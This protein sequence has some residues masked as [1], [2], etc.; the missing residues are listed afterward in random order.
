MPSSSLTAWTAR[1]AMFNQ[2]NASPEALKAGAAELVQADYLANAIDF[3]A[4]AQ[5]AEGLKRLL[6]QV[7]DEGNFFLFKMIASQ[8]G[9][10]YQPK[11]GLETL[12]KRAAELGLGLYAEQAKAQLEQL[13]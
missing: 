3:L 2:K 11:A 13:G 8:L 5:D 1:L 6:P 4:K 9:P 7:I 12:L 10:G